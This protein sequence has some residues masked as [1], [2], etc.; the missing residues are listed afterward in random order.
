MVE[1]HLRLVQALAISEINQATCFEGSRYSPHLTLLYSQDVSKTL[2]SVLEQAA[3][4]WFVTPQTFQ[5]DRVA[6]YRKAPGDAY[7]PYLEIPL[8]GLSAT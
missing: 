3:R 2:F 7:R 6:I 5:T 8:L 1:L 4:D